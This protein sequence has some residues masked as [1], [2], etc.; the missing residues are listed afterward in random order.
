MLDQLKLASEE[1]SLE[2]ISGG[3]SVA[4]ALS[5]LPLYLDNAKQFYVK[6][7]GEPV[8]TL[9]AKKD[10]VWFAQKV[11][12]VSYVDLREVEVFVP[13]GLKTDL[14]SYS[15]VLLEAASYTN[16]FRLEVLDPFT[17]WLAGKLAEPSSLNSLRPALEIEG[18]EKRDLDKITKK[19]T[20]CF[21]EKAANGVAPYGK[22]VKRN[23]DWTKIVANAV[24]L[25]ARF[26]KDD[27]ML[28]LQQM[29]KTTDLLDTL[30]NRIQ[31]EPETYQV[32]GPVVSSIAKVAY[33]VAK[34]I[35]FYGIVRFRT[36]EFSHALNETQS[37]L[38]EVIKKL[39]H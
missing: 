13:A 29:N 4:Q 35:E 34:E 32:S 31:Q 30:L 28:V 10:L 6:N 39:G 18:F 8:K 14:L 5:R 9:F 22:A 3:A 11:Q 12:P 33:A 17:K 2:A 37:K 21:D 15:D 7:I 27:H 26:L 16:T 23:A 38:Q 24:E 19:L 36:E 25:Q 1:I 20:A